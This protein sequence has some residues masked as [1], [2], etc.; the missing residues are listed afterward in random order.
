MQL[1]RC[2]E[3]WAALQKPHCRTVIGSPL[4]M[5]RGNRPSE[6]STTPTSR[7]ELIPPNINSRVVDA[8]KTRVS[9]KLGSLLRDGSH[10]WIRKFAPDV[11]SL[12]L[13]CG[14]PPEFIDSL[15]RDGVWRFHM[16]S[17]VTIAICLK[18]HRKKCSRDCRAL[19]QKARRVLFC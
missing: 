10:F 15:E 14:S 2:E 9:W 11:I 6:N 5:S 16:F 1:G 13:R 7:L 4:S 8:V 17:C 18:S 12:T 3:V 19:L